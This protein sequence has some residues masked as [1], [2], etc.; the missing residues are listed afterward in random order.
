MDKENDLK[1]ISEIK[2]EILSTTLDQ[3]R[4][5]CAVFE[6]N[7][8]REGA[9]SLN[10][11]H[12][13]VDKQINALNERFAEYTS[14]EKLVSKYKDYGSPASF[15]K[16]G[17]RV[18][19]LAEEVLW[20][21]INTCEDLKR[22]NNTIKVAATTFLI[23]LVCKIWKEWQKNIDPGFRIEI[24]HVHSQE[25]PS[26]LINNPSIDLCFGGLLANENGPLNDLK[27]IEFI[28]YNRD[29]IG[30]LTNLPEE[31][32]MNEPIEIDNF[33]KKELLVILPKQGII[34]EFVQILDID[35][36]KKVKLL[37]CAQDVFF[38][39]ALLQ[40]DI[41]KACMFCH[42]NIADWAINSARGL[43]FGYGNL[44]FVNLLQKEPVI[45]VSAG[46]FRE[47][48]IFENYKKDHPLNLCWN[49]YKKWVQELKKNNY[50]Q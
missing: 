13:S 14:G 31:I 39:A 47:K 1:K 21:L 3:L 48:G 38:I 19:R 44:R 34:K 7:S 32:L 30:I 22:L 26:I 40:N 29:V 28:E 49:I 2:S 45:E 50:N 11:E 25:I 35:F 24:E 15:S 23:P 46:L 4:S 16:S 36:E 41:Y 42:K 10:R 37:E 5:L 12:A 33:F 6:K 18:K 43:G 17:E 27:N 8:I 20:A 9:K